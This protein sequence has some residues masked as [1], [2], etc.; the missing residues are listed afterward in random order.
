MPKSQ[1]KSAASRWR[2]QQENEEVGEMEDD[3]P[4]QCFGPACVQQTRHGSKYCSDECGMKLAKRRIYEILPSQI[5]RWPSSPCVGEEN[6][7][8]TLE[9]VRKDQEEVR[10]S[11]GELDRK[12]QELDALLDRCKKVAIDQDLDGGEGEDE[13]ELS[14]Y[15]VTC[16][17]EINQRGAFKHME[18]CFTKFEA[19]TSFG[20]I[21]KTRI[22]GNS[23][24]CDYYNP[25]QK[26]YCKRLKVLCPEHTK[27][28]KVGPDEVCGSP[29]VSNVFE[30]KEEYCR[31]SK[32]KCAKHF[33]W[34]KLRRAEIDLERLR[35]WMKLDE[36]L[37]QER[38]VRMAMSNRM[39]VLG[40]MLHQ[41]IDHDP[42]TPMTPMKAM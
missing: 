38:N 18:K 14:I 7:K 11:I 3:A 19:Q 32:R 25:Q 36:L 28:R 31:V 40:L 24:F 5:Q 29:V 6:N 34:E 39:G 21:Y 15:C 26:T 42:M 13:T 10:I 9:K 2:Q 27:E 12:H 35:Q 4:R 30:E 8:K 22:E 16:G 41:T 17:Q 1:Q 23:M 20:S 33:C 37:E